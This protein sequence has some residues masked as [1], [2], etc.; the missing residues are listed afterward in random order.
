MHSRAFGRTG[1]RVPVLGFGAMQLGDPRIDDGEAGRLLNAVVDAGLAL[2]DTARSYGVS[3]ERIGRHL[4]HR[5]GE[6][7]LSTKVGYGVPGVPDWTGECIL[8]GVDAARA[9][10]RTETIDIVQLHSCGLD[11]LR[12]SE[13]AGAL[14]RCVEQGKIRVAAYS[15]DDDALDF[16]VASGAFGSF[17][18]SVSVCDQRSLPILERARA[19]GAGTIAK[20]T[21]AGRPWAAQSAP[22]DP[23]HG[24]YYRRFETLRR[25][26]QATPGDW[27]EVALRFAAYEEPVDCVIVGGTNARH[28]ERNLAAVTKGPLEPGLH[29]A[30]RAAFE[31]QGGD[32]RGLV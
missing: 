13:V 17:Q 22:A 1:L 27:D 4:A 28:V 15:G 20:R 9:R 19:Q 12:C 29:A 5:R 10:L 7:I 30:I 8:R 23:T 18:T 3:E 14:L 25:E 2:I 26:L 11:T 32:W 21:F 16:A 31:K 24:E 6:I